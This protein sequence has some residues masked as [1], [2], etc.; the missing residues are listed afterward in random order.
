MTLERI[1]SL[2][3]ADHAE[4]VAGK[5]YVNGGGFSGLGVVDFAKPVRFFMA[6]TLRVLPGGPDRTLAVHANVTNPAG[7]VVGV[8]MLTGE[9]DAPSTGGV[10]VIAGPVELDLD[11][12]G[13]LSL[14]LA[15]GGAGAEVP[16][17]VEL[18]EWADQD[19]QGPLRLRFDGC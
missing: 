3:L 13:P 16:F 17:M 7:E 18:H 12:P 5:L 2:L 6:A 11:S 9:L 10:A 15:F 1:D 8:W 14:R 19:N 4:V